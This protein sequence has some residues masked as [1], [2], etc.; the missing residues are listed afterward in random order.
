MTA[1]D[2]EANLTLADPVDRTPARLSAVAAVGLLAVAVHLVA[3]PSA[4][5]PLV[6]VG[7]GVVF[8]GVGREVYRRE[9]RIAAVLLVAAG[10]IGAA[11]AVG[12]AV[13]ETAEPSGLLRLLPGLVGVFAVGLAL[14]P[15]R[16]GWSRG[17]L[18]I[19]TALAL[20]SV[21]VCGILRQADYWTLAAST[22]AAV[23]TWDLGENAVGIGEQL[24]RKAETT[25][26]ETTHALGSGLV[27]AVA[28]F[29]GDA[30]GD[31]GTGGLSLPSLALVLLALLFL[32][33]ALFD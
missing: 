28:V 18:K 21:L 16:R 5:V 4:A 12:V 31:I 17:L 29:A 6:V 22:A 7:I 20:V 15:V 9:R 14:A 25:A 23:V 33:A 26:I 30:A 19:G 1:A 8:V 24:G 3:P 13:A 11:A 10:F 2:A 32:S 27:G